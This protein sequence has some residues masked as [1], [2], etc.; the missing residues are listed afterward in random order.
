M[1]GIIWDGVGF[2]NLIG[3]ILCYGLM[4]KL[5]FTMISTSVHSDGIHFVASL[6]FV[7][8]HPLLAEV[9]TPESAVVPHC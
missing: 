3:T 7:D 6:S 1:S 4:V 9:E 2:P 8:E 5:I